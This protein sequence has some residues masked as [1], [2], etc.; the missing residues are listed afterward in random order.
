MQSYLLFM[1]TAPVNGSFSKTKIVIKYNWASNADD[2]SGGE[3]V[4]FLDYLDRCAVDW[5]DNKPDLF[6]GSPHV[7]SIAK[8]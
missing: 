1:S 8:I 6:G 3:I 2:A 5:F 7:T 4:K